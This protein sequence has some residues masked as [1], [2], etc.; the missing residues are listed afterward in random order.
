MMNT[1]LLLTSMIERAEKYFPEKEVVSRTLSGI[2]R[3][4]YK[5][6]GERT[7]R[8]AHALEKLGMSR[9]EKIGTFAWNHHRHLE[10][11]FAIP[12]RGAII[13]MINIRLSPEHIAYV[14]NHAE[15][16]ILLVDEDL[17]P[18]I[19]AVAPHLQTVETYIIMSDSKEIPS[20]SL[21]NVYSYEA[22]LEEAVLT[23]RS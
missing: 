8:L 15:D 2:H 9:G 16:K 10:A 13:H 11:Y 21:K 19:E 4:T 12:C 5:E 18:L 20:T 1:P 14:I 22:I 7:R 6:I 3:Y 17:L 23:I